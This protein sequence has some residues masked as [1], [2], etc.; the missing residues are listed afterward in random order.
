MVFEVIVLK[1]LARM[2]PRL[3]LLAALAVLI[4]VVLLSGCQLTLPQST[5][6]PAGDVARSQQS[7]FLLVFWISVIIFILVQGF[8]II[9]VI[10]YRSRKGREQDVPPQVHGNTKL[11]IGW[12]IL[13]ALLVIGITIPTVA[14]IG[15]TYDAPDSYADDPVLTIEVVGH[16][17]WWEYRYLDD[18]GE[19]DF[20]TANELHIPIDTVINIKLLSADVIHSFSVPRLAGTRDAVPGRENRMWLNATET[21]VYAG[22]CK[23]FCGDSHALMRTVAFGREQADYEA[24]A[25]N[26]RQPAVARAAEMD[27]GWTVFQQNACRG[28]HGIDGANEEEYPLAIGISGPNLSHFG[29]RVTIAANTLHKGPAD[30]TM[31]AFFENVPTDPDEMERDPSNENLRAWLSNAP[32]EKPGTEMPDLDLT[33]QQL[34]DLVFF[35]EN[36]K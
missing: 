17:W 31:G 13:P 4:A 22:Q 1:S 25:E 32:A 18:M 20:V 21:G 7:L 12:T 15:A 23:E 33:E 28:C 29:S 2:G 8:L 34:N 24:W 3:Q 11:E 36:L 30:M 35:L 6:Y 19:L 27:A 10:K 5:L 26:E 9:A 14:G 16:Q